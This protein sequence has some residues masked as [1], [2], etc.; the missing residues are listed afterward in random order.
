MAK[1]KRIITTAKTA[2]KK[3]A[4]KAV[5]TVKAVKKEVRDIKQQRGIQKEKEKFGAFIGAETGIPQ[6]YKSQI[7]KKELANAKKRKRKK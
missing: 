6:K 3:V 5:T 2:L 1:A 7:Q 4:T